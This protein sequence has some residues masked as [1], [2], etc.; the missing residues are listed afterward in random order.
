MPPGTNY[1]YGGAQTGRGF[2]NTA[3]ALVDGNRECVSNIGLQVKDYLEDVSGGVQTLDENTLLVV[4][5]GSNNSA[6]VPAAM[7]IAQHVDALASA[8]G[9]LFLVPNMTRLTNDPWTVVDDQRWEIWVNDFNDTLQAE[10]GAVEAKH[11]ESGVTIMQ[12]NW[13]EVFDQ[14]IFD[15]QL[16]DSLGLENVTE[17]V[18]PACAAVTDPAA[19]DVLAG[20]PAAFLYWDAFHTTRVANKFMGEATAAFV[21]DELANLPS[22]GTAGAQAVPEPTSMQLVMAAAAAAALATNARRRCPAQSS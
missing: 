11:Q 9:K 14:L 20:D 4:Q 1:A 15:E 7:W 13:F 8:G 5:G 12:M 17:P 3:C 22:V 6:A 2:N 16:Q 21:L 10:L 19:D 18:C